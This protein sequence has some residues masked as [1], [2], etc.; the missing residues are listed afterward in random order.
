ML[1]APEA[2]ELEELPLYYTFSIWCHVPSQK[3]FL[4][5]AGNSTERQP[6][7]GLARYQFHLP[8]LY[9]HFDNIGYIMAAWV[10]SCTFLLS[11]TQISDNS[12]TLFRYSRSHTQEHGVVKSQPT[13]NHPSKQLTIGVPYCTGATVSSLW[14]ITWKTNISH[15][16]QFIHLYVPNDLSSSGI[17]LSVF[18]YV[19]KDISGKPLGPI[20]KGQAAQ[21]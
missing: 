2:G 13:F 16:S 15:P 3:H 18:H 10:C 7:S 20:F 17:L 4:F 5:P 11:D 19:V 6:R 8:I 12:A 21:E 9:R 1:P 14:R